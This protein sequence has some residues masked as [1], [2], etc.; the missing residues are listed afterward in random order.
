[1]SMHSLISAAVGML[2]LGCLAAPTTAMLRQNPQQLARPMTETKPALLAEG[3]AVYTLALA[4]QDKNKENGNMDI[5]IIDSGWIENVGGEFYHGWPTVANMG[6]DRLAAVCSGCRKGHID[7]YGR[8]CLYVSDDMGKT[9]TGPQVL[10]HGPLDDRD[11]GITLAPDG[12]WLVNYF[13][14]TCF[15]NCHAPENTPEEW[16][17]VE[18]SISLFTLKKEHGFFLLRSTDQGKTWSEKIS[19]PVNNVHGSVI[20]N[21]GSLFWA[22]RGKGKTYIVEDVFS[23]D[24]VFMRST[25]NGLT[26]ELVGKISNGDFPGHDIKTWNVSLW[27]ELSCVQAENGSIVTQIRDCISSWTFQTI[28]RDGGKTWS[29]PVKLW[30]GHPSHLLKMKDGRLIS[31]YGYRVAG[32]DCGVRC[33]VSKDNGETWS[34]D[35]T[36]SKDGENGDLGY[37]STTQ[38]SDGTLF[39]LWY[40]WFGAKGRALLG[41]ARWALIE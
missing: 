11:A 23:D 12:S 39:T 18:E 35:L 34:N 22:G 10:T 15:A 9:W 41:W 19:V 40:Q 38:L 16:R 1:M 27:H 2:C 20:L 36:I 3:T 32:P 31:T 13:T 21:D 29:E 37:P 24:V 7:P 26:W 25:D 8:V 14:N 28:S 6:N 33:R 4:E 30:Y 17:K 5:K